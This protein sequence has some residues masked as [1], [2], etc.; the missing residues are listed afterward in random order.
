MPRAVAA[1][2]ALFLLLS[3]ST[4]A[5]AQGASSA[6]SLFQEARALTERGQYA[7]ACP[8]LEKSLELEPAVGTQ[9]NLA[10]CYEHIGRTASAHAMFEEVASIARKAGKFERER[11]AKERAAAL[12]PKLARAR[13]VVS[14]AAPGLEVRID[15]TL[16]DRT[17]WSAAVAVDPGTHRIRA[18]APGRRPFAG[19]FEAH[20]SSTVDTTVPELVE[21]EPRRR[22][23]T[24]PPPIVVDRPRGPSPLTYV[25]GG[26][27]IAALATGTIAGAI[28][29][30]KRSDAQSECPREVYAFRCPTESGADA[31]NGATTAGD[32][33]TIG[34]VVAGVTLAA[35]AVLWITTSH[36]ARARSATSTFRLGGT[37]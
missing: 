26:V 32:V 33:A 8:K 2:A 25:I 22:E 37:F 12:E 34:F 1:S 14:S 36:S 20:A 7:E 24:A 19:S 11:S 15:D 9:F 30:S 3:A 6:E 23:A 16:V 18:S 29:L 35:T 28:A 4:V 10:D 5:R 21:I 27:G 31:W 17:K 13:I